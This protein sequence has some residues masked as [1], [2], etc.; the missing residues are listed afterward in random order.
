MTARRGRGE[1]SLYWDDQRKRWRGEITIGYDARGKRITRKAS[2]K[3]KTEA[4][5]KLKEIQRDYEE[6]LIAASAKDTV[7]DAIAYWLAYGLSGRDENTIDMYRTYAETHVIPA[8]GKRPLRELTVDEVEK[9]LAEKSAVLSTR[10]LLIIHSVLRRAIQKAQTRDKV[11]RNIILLCEVPEGRAGRPSKSLT[12]AQAEAVL[13]AAD[14]ARLRIRAYIIVSLLTG[15]RTEEMR[16][17]RWHDVNLV[18]KPDVDLPVPPHVELVRS[19]RAGGDTKTRTSRRAVELA[20]RVVDVLGLLWETRTC[21]HTQ[22]S[23]CPCLVFVT[24][25]GTPLGARNVQRDFRKVIDAAGLTGKEWTP[26]ELRQSFVSLLSDAKVPVEVISR[27]VGHRST[28]VTETVYRK[29]LRPV[30]EGGANVMD[31]IFPPDT[32]SET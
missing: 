3:T 1:G 10:S 7:G 6:G 24:R 14:R 26:R 28:T 19:V 31:R 29:Q 9:F 18:G 30:I 11:R 32:G 21:S 2:G 5:N 13:K 23:G 27:L 12:L 4:K 25:N 8:L 20:Q 22:T 15:A 16:A 17:L